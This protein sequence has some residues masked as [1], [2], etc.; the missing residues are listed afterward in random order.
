TSTSLSATNRGAESTTPVSFDLTPYLGDLVNGT[1][2]LAFHAVNSA[3][4]SPTGSGKDF[5]LEPVLTAKRATASITGSFMP[6]PTPGAANGLGTLGFIADTQFSVQ[7]GFFTSPF[8]VTLT[9]ATPGAQI[10][11]TTDGTAPTATTG[12]VYSAPVAINTTT[13]LRAAAFKS[14]WT[15]TNVDTQTYLFLADVIHQS[16]TNVTKPYATWGHD[17]DGD[18]LSG[19]NLDNEADWDM[20]PDIVNNPAWSSTIINDLQSI[21]TMSVVMNWDD[22]FGGTPMPGTPAGTTT[23]APAPQGI[24]IHGRSD[25]R[26]ASLEFF[27]PAAP[28]DQFQID[29]AIEIQGHSSPL[30]WNTDKLSFQVKF[31]DP[32]GPSKL[33]YPVFATGLYGQSTATEFDSL[34]LDAIYNWGWTH[35]NPAQYGSA[36]FV[37][38]QVLADLQGQ[39]GNGGGPHG[40]YVHLYLNGLYWGIYNVHERPDDSFAEEYYGG[41]KDDYDVIKHGSDDVSHNY[42]WVEGGE[43]AEGRY[44]TLVNATRDVQS[45]PTNAAKYQA[46]TDLLDVDAFIDY[47]IVHFY[48]GNIIDWSNNNW[49]ATRDRVTAGA[50][51]TFHEWDQEHAFPAAVNTDATVYNASGESETPKE[52]NNNL[53]ANAEYKLRFNDRMQKLMRNGGVLTPSPA[54]ATYQAR[55]DEIN[56]A[57]VGESARWGDNRVPNDPFDRND[58]LSTANSLMSGFFPTRTNVVLGQ[59]STRGWAVSLGAPVFSL[60][61]GS[62]SPGTQLTLTKPAGSPANA[63]IYYTLDG[64]DPRLPGGTLSP[65]ALLYTGPITINAS[66]QVRSRVYFDTTG[67]VNDFSPIVDAAF[68]VGGLFPVR[69]T[70]LNYHPANH[71]GIT[72]SDDI[73][74]IELLNTSSQTVD[75][76]GMTI[77]VAVDYTFPAGI[78]LAPGQRIVVARN[79]TI[80]TQVYGGGINLAPGNYTG[81]LDNAGERVVLRGPLNELLQDFTYDDAAPWPTSP[82]GDGPTLEI[83]DPLGDPTNPA[84]WRASVVDGGSPGSDGVVD[85]APPTVQ[86]AQY[87]FEHGAVIIQFSENVLASLQGDE[88]RMEPLPGGSPTASTSFTYN[89]PNNIA[90]FSFGTALPDG[91]Y[92]LRLPAGAVQDAAGNPLAEFILTDPSLFFLGGDANRDRKVDATDLGILSLN[93]GEAG[94]T[95]SQGNFDYSPDGRVGVDDLNILAAHWQQSLAAPVLSPA[96]APVRAPI[97]RPVSRIAD[98]VVGKLASPIGAP[99]AADESILM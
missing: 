7:R 72:D 99:A 24:Y 58:F 85:T 23:V 82:D 94:R 87:D 61:G 93:W 67:I 60:L 8:T 39:T 64:S 1:N 31:K 43:A 53:M 63:V 10:R 48:G 22:L 11:Y 38:D 91:N 49:Y 42:T 30:R 40:R 78:S 35:Q 44:A 54:Q 16:S 75:L 74:F 97:A 96:P 26:A 21:P 4:T 86:S 83:I 62:V 18:S 25:E 3:S 84:N 14:G 17:K 51:W 55:V 57:I 34:I 98:D 29:S 6:T 71:A 27:N 37:T 28:T 68:Q 65:S 69:I 92:Q 56:R 80:F 95:F 52:L 15:S 19:Y 12:T 20:D 81:K 36:K 66:E 76:A 47:M 79:Q 41:D 45:D 9:T 77:S 70:E 2:V 32:F 73:E 59:F 46:V 90:S 50:K 88:V 13:T 33:D 5:L 89:V